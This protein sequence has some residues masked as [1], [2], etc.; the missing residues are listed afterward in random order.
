MLCNTFTCTSAHARPYVP[1]H[2][3]PAYLLCLGSYN[4]IYFYFLI[5]CWSLKH[6]QHICN[7]GPP[8]LRDNSGVL[9]GWELVIPTVSAKQRN[10]AV[11]RNRDFFSNSAVG[12]LKHMWRVEHWSPAIY[13]KNFN[14]FII[15]ELYFK[16][17]PTFLSDNSTH[18]SVQRNPNI[19]ILINSSVIT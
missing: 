3:L 17:K 10:F 5:T 9:K 4:S 14:N 15:K 13:V 6:K 7:I 19:Q 16:L 18:R 11:S 1:T 8:T 12:D 2:S